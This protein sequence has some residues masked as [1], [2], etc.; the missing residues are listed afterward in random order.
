MTTKDK[1]SINSYILKLSGKA[2]IPKPL[3]IGHNFK[4]KIDGSI[5]AITE[6]DNDDG[7]RTYYYKFEPVLVEMV[8]EK[9]ETIKAKDVRSRSRQLRSRLWG[10]WQEQNIV[11]EFENFYDEAM[12]KI[13][14]NAD[15]FVETLKPK[16]L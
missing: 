8:T 2:E 12:K 14:Y 4:I 10:I 9:G 7:S 1:N 6:S 11:G 16:N 13:I 3:E 5:T 15:D